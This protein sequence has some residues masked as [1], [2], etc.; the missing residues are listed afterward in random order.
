MWDERLGGDEEG[1]V[2]RGRSM[3]GEGWGEGWLGWV[4]IPPSCLSGGRQGGGTHLVG[5][6][7]T[8]VWVL[9][10]TNEASVPVIDTLPLVQLNVVSGPPN[11]WVA[12]D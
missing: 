11:A 2:A 9:G 10:V 7:D 1:V 8:K 3:G 5:P 4:E 6:T 12:C